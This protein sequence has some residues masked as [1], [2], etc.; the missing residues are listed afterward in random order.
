MLFGR[1]L[2]I[3]IAAM[4]GVWTKVDDDTLDPAL[5]IRRY[6]ADRDD[7]A[8]G[9][10]VDGDIT[11]MATT[12]LEAE[13]RIICLNLEGCTIFREAIEYHHSPP[14]PNAMVILVQIRD[15]GKI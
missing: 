15:L 1:E 2:S 13:I 7:L 4:L 6:T 9:K 8:A 10:C 14:V 3:D 11:S 12:P 5:F